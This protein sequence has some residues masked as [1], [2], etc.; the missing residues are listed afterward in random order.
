M[1]MQIQEYIIF[2][3]PHLTQKLSDLLFSVGDMQILS[4]SKMRDL[5]VFFPNISLFMIIL[6]VFVSLL[7]FTCV[8]YVEFETF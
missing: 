1:Q 5:G 6:V 7:I 8:A 2:G 3:S 4:S